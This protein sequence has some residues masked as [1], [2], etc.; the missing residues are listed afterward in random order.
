ME[1]RLKI[2]IYMGVD[3]GADEVSC[4]DTF[5]PNDWTYDGVINYGDFAILSRAWLSCDPNVY[6]Y[7]PDYDYI[8]YVKRWG[9]QADM[10]KDSCVDILDLIEFCDPSDPNNWLWEACWRESYVAVYCM[11]DGGG[12]GLGG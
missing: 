9:F 4:T 7:D 6:G 5:D 11:M 8:W 12:G 1:T 2:P 3:I 10:N